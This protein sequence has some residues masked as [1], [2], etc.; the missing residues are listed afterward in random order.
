MADMEQYTRL[1]KKL[2]NKKLY[3]ATRHDI[4]PYINKKTLGTKDYLLKVLQGYRDRGYLTVS[5]LVD[6]YGLETAP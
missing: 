3:S 2:G 5:D 1:K 6:W 4:E